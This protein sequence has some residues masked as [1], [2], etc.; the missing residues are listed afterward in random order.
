MEGGNAHW[1]ELE[2]SGGSR[3][4]HLGNLEMK[5]GGSSAQEHIAPAISRW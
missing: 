4:R 2:E 3:A 5:G 1:L